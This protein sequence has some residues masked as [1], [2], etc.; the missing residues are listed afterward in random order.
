MHTRSPVASIA[1]LCGL[2]GACGAPHTRLREPG[3]HDEL[4]TQLVAW[5]VVR[6]RAQASLLT[7][8]LPRIALREAPT[9]DAGAGV[10]LHTVAVPRLWPRFA[11]VMMAW[12]TICDRRGALHDDVFGYAMAWCRHARQGDRDLERVLVG[13]VASTVPGL[14]AAA[15]DDLVN[16]VADAHDA[17]SAMRILARVSPPP[18]TLEKLAA[19]YTGLGR[20]DDADVVRTHL[21]PPPPAPPPQTGCAELTLA[22]ETFVP[23][24]LP[25]I[26]SVA[27][28]S[29]SC[30]PLARSIVCRIAVSAAT[31]LDPMCG[32]AGTTAPRDDREAHY[33]AAYARWGT[34]WF[35]VVD[36][37]VKA[38]PE[39]GA[40]QVAISALA[41]SLRSGCEPDRLDGVR[42]RAN[43]LLREPAHDARWT[44]TLRSL[45]GITPK[46]C[47]GLPVSA[48]TS[49]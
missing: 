31:P 17:A 45:A 22:L 28:G 13:L 44:P 20:E 32:R 14:R 11:P 26:R 47:A 12:P 7:I 18:G 49:P 40:E 48:R 25:K 24:S 43:L 3:G 16:V 41:A 15:L 10:A 2:I 35:A 1:V 19:I 42:A 27:A 33:L 9:S 46:A 5:D 6:R 29:S 37:A 36:H 8:P 38:M 30:A 34:D 39:P 4:A 23:Q 21:P